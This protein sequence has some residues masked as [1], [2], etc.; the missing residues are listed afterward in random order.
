MAKNWKLLCG[1]SH[2]RVFTLPTR[3]VC[4]KETIAYNISQ[5][6]GV[7]DDKTFFISLVM[8][9]IKKNLIIVHRKL[10]NHCGTS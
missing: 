8:S 5:Q 3:I 1:L 6:K 9:Q 4:P 2:I 7:Y 10:F